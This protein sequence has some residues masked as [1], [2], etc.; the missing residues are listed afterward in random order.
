[1]CK[2]CVGNDGKS[3][4]I[5]L[6]CEHYDMGVFGK[7][8]LYIDIYKLIISFCTAI[9]FHY[10]ADDLKINGGYINL[11]TDQIIHIINIVVVWIF[12]V[13]H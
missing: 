11:I 13:F 9:V 5:P 8:D 6:L 1:M 12:Y 10:N 2:Y 3:D 7:G 4:T